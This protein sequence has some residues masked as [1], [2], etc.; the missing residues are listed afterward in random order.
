MELSTN[1]RK[2][3]RSCL[4]FVVQESCKFKTVR[5]LSA[6]AAPGLKTKKQTQRPSFRMGNQICCGSWMTLKIAGDL[7]GRQNIRVYCKPIKIL[8]DIDSH[9]CA[10][11]R[12]GPAALS[13][14][15]AR[16]RTA[17]DQRFGSRLVR[18]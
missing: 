10:V 5:D 9:A 6:Q 12:S 8:S 1:V 14:C 17:Y 3:R 16:G 11:C 7:G 13:D 15:N 18:G 2:S 4:E